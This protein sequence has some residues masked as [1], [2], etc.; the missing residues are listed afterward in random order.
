[1][2][3][4]F[5]YLHGFLFA[6]IAPISAYNMRLDVRTHADPASAWGFV[7]VSII[8][9]LCLAFIFLILIK[10]H[11]SAGMMGTFAVL[12]VLYTR[13]LFMPIILTILF[14]WLL[15]GITSRRIDIT[16]PYVASTILS[17]V[18]TIYFGMNFALFVHS[19]NWDKE[20]SMAI[21]VEIT[22][23]ASTI[24]IRPDIYYIIL[25]GYGGEEML[26]KLHGFDNSEF[27]SALKERGFIL[28]PEAKPNFTRTIHSLSLH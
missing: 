11:L 5:Y 22:V 25:D 3:N 8:F 20:K 13:E 26:N 6:L 12:G 27:T 7:I 28:P 24:R 1:M 15:L 2:K 21:P 17:I 23:P 18:I 19:V 14:A 10:D 16:H 4:I 9:Y